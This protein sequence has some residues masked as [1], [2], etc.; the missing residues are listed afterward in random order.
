VVIQGSQKVIMMHCHNFK[1]EA[2]IKRLWL[3]QKTNETSK[4]LKDEK[5]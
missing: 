2:L 5:K 3:A 1:D 4:K